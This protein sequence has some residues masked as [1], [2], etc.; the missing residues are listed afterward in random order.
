MIQDV[1]HPRRILKGAL[2]ALIVLQLAAFSL[3]DAGTVRAGEAPPA[4]KAESLLLA[5]LKTGR[6]LFSKDAGVPHIPASLSKIMTLYIA[7][8]EIAAGR[9]SMNDLV[10][11]S[12]KAWATEGSKMYILV[13]TKVKLEDLIKGITV[14]S[15]N[16]ACV[17]V[18]EYVSGSLGSFVDRMNRKAKELGM[19]ATR[20]VDPHGLSDDNKVSADDLL[21]LVRSYVTV[22]PEALLFHSMKEFAYTVPGETEKAPQFNRN[23]LLW[24]YPGTYGLK[25]GFT[26]LAGFNMI[27]LVERSG[28]H[29]IA[30]ILGAAKGLSIEDGE[31]ERSE[32][33]TSLLDWAYRN[34]AY[35]QIAEPYAVVANVR[36]WKGRGKYAEAVSLQGLG[37]TVEKGQEDRV[38]WLVSL[39]KDVSAPV[40]KGA[41]V[42]EVLFTVD[43]REAG[44]T[45]LV[46]KDDVPR[47]NVFRVL[48]DT[49][50]QTFLRAFT[51]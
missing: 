34:Y 22:H 42:G 39:K 46:A 25:T 15:G 31:R 49:I 33:I 23:R 10:P 41:K 43:G 12:E 20:L 38:E 30:I 28:F 29:A 14:M 5:D 1:R 18:A 3:L 32:M 27:T 9:I 51:K 11:I 7:F 40:G 4:V 13:G 6:V 16:D 19:A 48:W 50:S 47:G 2:C 37:A 24:T 21:V 36:V 35:V 45:D 17:A 26:T 44:R 8:D